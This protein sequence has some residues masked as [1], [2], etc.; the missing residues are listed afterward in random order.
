LAFFGCLTAGLSHDLKNVLATINEYAGLLDDLQML[1]RRGRPMTPERVQDVCEHVSAQV[2]RGQQMLERLSRLSHS[3]DRDRASVDANALVEDLCALSERLAQMRRITLE[4]R[5]AASP[6]TLVVDPMAL[7]HAVHL[8]IEAA[9]EGGDVVT[10]S[11]E[12]RAGGAAVVVAAAGP[13]EPWGPE[14]GRLSS[15]RGLVAALGAEL[16]WDGDVG[17]ISLELAGARDME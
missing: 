13:L 4:R 7:M 12:P 5:P 14:E 9:A 8:C 16:T 3:V 2:G 17:R 1:A 15:L 11:V 10:V 6:V